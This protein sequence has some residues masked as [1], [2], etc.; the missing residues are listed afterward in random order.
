MAVVDKLIIVYCMYKYICKY[1]SYQVGV[2]LCTTTIYISTMHLCSIRLKNLKKTLF[3][4]RGGGTGGLKETRNV[5]SDSDV[6]LI[7]LYEDKNKPPT[8]S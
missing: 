6:Q 2:P 5:T 4:K 1:D 3:I 7:V 8:P